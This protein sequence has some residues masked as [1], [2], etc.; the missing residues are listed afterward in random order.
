[1]RMYGCMGVVVCGCGAG[2]GRNVCVVMH[3][4]R[5]AGT[6]ARRGN[7]AMNGVFD[8]MKVMNARVLIGT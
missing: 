3:A 7:R 2:L 8:I 5:Q 4:C 1:M 6:R